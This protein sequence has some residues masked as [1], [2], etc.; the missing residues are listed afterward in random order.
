MAA[1]VAP[2]AA[3]ELAHLLQTSISPI[4][5][6]SGV[7][8]LLLSMT[9]RLSRVI[10]RSRSLSAQLRGGAEDAAAAARERIQLEVL[11]RR[12]RLLWISIASVMVTVLCACTMVLMLTAMAFLQA[13]LRVVVVSLFFVALLALLVSAVVFFADVLLSLRALRAEM[14]DAWR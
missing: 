9:N 5:L 13:N 7:G 6:I 11:A 14:G 2:E 4:A 10:D 12:A 8:L 1:P 3:G